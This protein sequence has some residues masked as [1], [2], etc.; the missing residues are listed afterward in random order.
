MENIRYATIKSE[1]NIPEA[2]KGVVSFQIADGQV[3]AVIV[4]VG[5]DFLRIVKPDS[6]STYLK[7]LTKEPKVK[8]ERFAVKGKYQGLVDVYEEFADKYERKVGYEDSGLT[9][10]AVTVE[11]DADKI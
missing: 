7:I 3:E 2:L 10:E 1:N 11:V 4:K 6:Y 5:D 8:V 9:V